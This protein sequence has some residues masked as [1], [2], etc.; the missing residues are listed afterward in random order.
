MANGG[1]FP[2]CPPQYRDCQQQPQVNVQLA[3][4]ASLGQDEAI[5]GLPKYSFWILFIVVIF[6]ENI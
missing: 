2:P 5:A 6:L 1:H 4:I 3:D